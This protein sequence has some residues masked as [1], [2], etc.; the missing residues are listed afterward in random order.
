MTLVSFLFNAVHLSLVFTP[1]YIYILPGSLINMI[2][3]Y[4]FLI[5]IMVPLHWH[6]N[7]NQCIFTN[8]TKNVGGLEMTETDSGFSEI[9]LRWLYEPIM[10]QIN[11]EWNNTNLTL[12]IYYHW[13][14]NFILLWYY[15]FFIYMAHL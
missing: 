9:Y 7:D 11:Y 4:V 6:I 1:V 10:K 15:N 2:F 12:M 3:P 13:I 8:I 5:L 14:F